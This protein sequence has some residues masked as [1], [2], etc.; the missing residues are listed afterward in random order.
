MTGGIAGGGTDMGHLV[1]HG[2]WAAQ[3]ARRAPA[4]IFFVDSK[5]AFYSA[6]AQLAACNPESDAA[7]ARAFVP[8]LGTRRLAR[9]PGR[10]G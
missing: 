2:W 9:R 8:Y 6:C 3:R 5:N 7:A 10:A 4:A 1:V